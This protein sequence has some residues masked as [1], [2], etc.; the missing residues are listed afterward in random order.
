MWW[1]RP[2]SSVTLS[3]K[4]VRHIRRRVPLDPVTHP[5]AIPPTAQ[6]AQHAVR[7]VT[8]SAKNGGAALPDDGMK[9]IYPRLSK[10][11]RSATRT[12]Q[13]HQHPERIVVLYTKGVVCPLR[14]TNP[15][16]ARVE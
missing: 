3:A 7:A 6:C 4:Y 11:S 9:S 8:H 10:H 5:R 16:T 12:R 13:P 14:I 15:Q 1:I 2:E